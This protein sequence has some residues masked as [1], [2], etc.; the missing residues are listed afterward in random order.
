MVTTISRMVDFEKVDRDLN[1]VMQCFCE[2]LEELG[3][4]EIARYLPWL[5]GG[6]VSIPPTMSIE[7]IA[8]AYSIAFQLLNM[9]EENAS[10]QNRRA[11]EAT[12]GLTEE[13]GLWGQNLQRLKELGLTDR[14]IA[15]TLPQIQVEPVLTA[16]PTEAKRATVLEHHRALYLLLVKREN[17]MWTPHEQQQIRNQVK[18]MLELLWRT[19][20]ILLKKPG[21]DSE[22]RNVIH[23]LRNVFPEALSWMDRRLREAWAE[24]G[25]DPEL[26]R[27]AH[28]LPR[29][30]IGTWVGGDRDGHP[31]VTAEVTRQTLHT[32][33]LNALTLL[34]DRLSGLVVRLSLSGRRQPTPTRLLSR[35]AA[36]GEILGE[37][38]MQAI[39]R[40]PGEPWRQMV[41]LMLARL[42]VE[43]SGTETVHLQEDPTRYRLA[44]ELASD[45][46]LLYDSL[47]EVG[48]R[49]VA[50]MDVQPVIRAVQTFGFHLAV[51]DI[52]QNSRV[53]DQALSQG[54]LAAGL[55]E[56]ADFPHWDEA[57][58][59]EFLNCELATPRPFT[60]L[61]DPLGP[62]AEAVIS[63]YR[64]LVEHLRTYGPDGLGA[65]II[66]MTRSLS[67][68]LVVYVLAREARLT[69]TTTEG[70]GCQ[71]PVVP[72]FE[73][74]E[75]LT[76]SPA[77][78]REFLNHPVT[79]R[80]L[81]YQRERAGAAQPVQQ[82]MIG[83]SDSNKD[84]GILASQ[85]NLYQAQE[86][87]I[88][89]GMNCGVRIR[90]F[91]GRGGTISRGAGPTH[92]FL[93]ALP[94]TS[95][96]GD[97][98]LTEQGEVIAQ[99]YANLINAVFNLELLTAGTTEV[100]LRHRHTPN[101]CLPIEAVIDR[102]AEQSHRA[103]Q[104][105]LHTEG[106]LPFFRQATPIDVIESSRIGSRP[107]RRS[108]QQS[109]D[110]LR[111]IPWVFSWNQARFYLSGWYGVGWALEELQRKDPET[112]RTICQYAFDWPPLHYIISNIATSIATA[113]REMMQAYAAMVEAAPIRTRVLDRILEEYERT[114]RMLEVL[115]DGPLEER[116]P[117]IHK[118][119]RMRQEGL[120]TL[121][122]RQIDLLRI[123]RCLKQA[124]DEDDA[125]PV[126]LQLLLTVNAI[127]S[128]L[129]TTG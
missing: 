20:E 96:E 83:Y 12:I 5:D 127:A 27:E 51:L 124:G 89:V 119:L 123:W 81:E 64:V 11:I 38:G 59:L 1:F 98:R 53:H 68:L 8:Q 54:M 85:W 125:E 9:V 58:R 3:E 114:L 63:C 102:L 23:Y 19:G 108:G 129:R 112:F 49:R 90:F 15:E 126:L 107:A 41:N 121:H 55:K 71:L 22:V 39:R 100:T 30:S 72:L 46:Q 26:L 122:H 18:T 103:Y 21:V 87:L 99:K 95:V 7:H 14:Q 110:D 74:I 78:L 28:H 75:D 45:M 69:F 66:S 101:V 76:N 86:R 52:R 34:H 62:D 4:H 32:L 91:H 2:V 44:S 84:G 128:G 117:R 115:Y 93:R 6:E 42:P 48:S 77:I 73:T 94:H 106:F 60:H 113:D 40:N 25:F 65:L 116:R 35:I 29:L 111:A 92:R 104:T 105:L 120:H 37:E 56:G 57:R 13:S 97:L 118:A 67:D 17:Q 88:E 50:D 82:V 10:A 36:L 31:L 47:V 16:H 70:L 79:R 33:R 80:S 61:E 109:L 43:V 24:A